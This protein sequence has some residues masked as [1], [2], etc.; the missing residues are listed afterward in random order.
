VVDHFPVARPLALLLAVGTAALAV[1][2]VAAPAHAA[3]A[4]TTISIE[5]TGVHGTLAVHQTS[6]TDLF[7]RLLHQV[8]WMATRAG[9]PMKPDQ[10]KLGPKY[11]L[12]VSAGSKLL[13]RYEMYPQAAGGPKAFRPAD[14]PQGRVVEGWYYVSLSV[15]ELLHAAG[16]PL[17]D[18]D[19][20]DDSGALVYRDPAGYVPGGVNSDNQPLV[21][22][23]DMMHAQARTLALWAGTALVV[24]VVVVGAA[25][26]SR[27]YS[28]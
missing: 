23:T 19:S 10:A 14:Q 16:V 3:D 28:S 11:T 24:L 25:R 2:S 22:L 27:R 15:P 20:T 9:D 1:L 5:G 12:T 6:Q 8:S 17:V 18:A 21:S 13:Q 4:P 7:N 26:L